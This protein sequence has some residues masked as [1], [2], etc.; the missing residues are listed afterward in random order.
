MGAG[1]QFPVPPRVAFFVSDHPSYNHF[2]LVDPTD[3]E[4]VY[5]IG[6]K[7][8]SS[9]IREQDNKV[10]RKFISNRSGTDREIALR[11]T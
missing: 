10:M 5:H 7:F 1:A 11:I 2:F 3:R 8:R 6:R 9:I 4:P